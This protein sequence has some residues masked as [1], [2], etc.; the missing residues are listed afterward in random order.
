MMTVGSSAAQV[1]FL[2]EATCPESF[3]IDQ[4]VIYRRVQRRDGAIAESVVGNHSTDRSP[5]I[6]PELAAFADKAW[7]AGSTRPIHLWPSRTVTIVDLFCGVGGTTVGICEAARALGMRSE[8]AC[9]VD[10]DEAALSVYSRNLSDSAALALDL[11]SVSSMLGSTRTPAEVKLTKIVSDKPD[12]LVAGPPCQ[13]HSNLNNHTRRDD[14]KN[15]LYF[16]VVRAV[17]LL[18]PRFVLIEN[19]P[20]VVRDKRRAMPRAALALESLGYTVSHSIVDASML[21]VA[22]TRKRHILM[23]IDRRDES[24]AV[25]EIGTVESIARSY[26]VEPRSVLW[27]ID[28]LADIDR[29]VFF[30]QSLG[31][32]EE[33]R[34]RIN[35]LFD[36]GQFNLPDSERPECHRNKEHTYQAVYGRMYPDRPAPTITSGFFTMGQGRFVHPIR[37]STL[38]AHEAARVQFFPDWFDWSCMDTRAAISKGIGNAVPP[39]LSYVFALEAFR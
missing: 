20:T 32:T 1:D 6:D 31:A 23:A 17:E 9:A 19:V 30:D 21:G 37:R 25:G 16:K 38:T 5:S 36:T 13:G 28:D 35:Y 33:T 15:E 4:G 39:K 10:L 7:L 8:I 2:G 24:L 11:S 18:R 27:A 26:A 3:R 12:I 14:P 29:N 34:R 22:Q